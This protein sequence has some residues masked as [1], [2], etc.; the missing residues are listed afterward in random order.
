M[1]GADS[2]RYKDATAVELEGLKR[3]CISLIRKSDVP[4]GQTSYPTSINWVTKFINGA[5]DKTKCRACFAGN[6][7]DKTY[8]DC[9]APTAN[10]MSVLIILCL[11][12]MF[13]WFVTGLDYEMAYLN[14]PMP[15]PCFMRPPTCMQEYDDDGEPFFWKCRT[16]IYG[17]PRSAKLWGDHL[18]KSFRA[19]GFYQLRSDSCVFVKW[20]DDYTMAIVVTHSDDCIVTS[21]NRQYGDA[22]RRDLLQMFKGKDLGRLS[23]FCGV[24][25]KQTDK[26]MELSLRHYLDQMFRLMT[27]DDKTV[28]SVLTRQPLKRDCPEIPI[29]AVKSQ[30]LKIVGMLIWVYTHCRF[31]LCL[32]IHMVTR[33]M[34][35]PS[36]AHLASLLHFCKYIR[37]TISWNLCYHRVPVLVSAPFRTVDFV[38]KCYCDSS[39][40]DDPDTSCSTSGYFIFLQ[41]GQGAIQGKT[42]SAKSPQLSSTEAEYI[43]TAEGAR[44]SIWVKQLLDELQIFRSVKF[45]IMEDSRPCINALRKNMA[46]SRFRHVRIYY[47]FL[48]DLIESLW[49]AVVEIDTGDQIADLCTKIL[50][51]QTT[52]KHSLSALGIRE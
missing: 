2:Q 1:E 21:N 48:R 47:H 42:F 11:S 27:L 34:H 45:E 44:S 20:Q 52:R 41:D 6:R 35:S 15:E 7:Y 46:D 8:S 19:Y 12:A 23:S 9:Y 29:P 17:H 40:A 31:D 4:R 28:Q 36:E 16:A 3:K 10:F 39:H 5:Y 32:P 26:G 14:A 33:V 51:I 30:Y 13:G 25:I 24:E 37:K 49:C 22:V 38:F 18:A 50:P 43:A